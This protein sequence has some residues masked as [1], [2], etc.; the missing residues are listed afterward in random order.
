MRELALKALE[1]LH[2]DRAV[3][4]VLLARAWRLPA[5]VVTVILITR[6]LTA[7]LQGFY[8]TFS[9]VLAFGVFLELGFSLVIVN[10]AGHEWA[11]L[12]LDRE[13]R[14]V[15][16]PA[17]LSRLVSLGRLAFRWYAAGA[18]L[19]FVLIASAGLIFFSRQSHPGVSWAGPWT[20]LA[21]FSAM[22]FSM[23]SVNSL[24]EGCNQV[25]QVNRFRLYQ[26]VATNL[27]LWTGLNL[28]AELWVLPLS[29]ATGLLSNLY[30]CVAH[31]GKFFDAFRRV[32][33]GQGIS[34]REEVWPMQWRVAVGGVTSYFA[35]F[36][37]N[38]IM[39]HYHGPVVAG[40]MGMTREAITV[41]EQTAMAWVSTKV[42][43]YGMLI[44]RKQ[45]ADLDRLWQRCSLVSLGV[46]VV[47]SGGLLALVYAL[48]ALEISLAG[49]L[50]PLLPTGV[51]LAASF[52]T[53]ISQCLTGYL[54]AHKQEPIMALTVTTGLSIGLA[55]WVLG[56]HYGPIGAAVG[57]LG[58]W[59]IS[60]I[61]ERSIWTRCRAEWHADAVGKGG[62]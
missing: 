33:T 19:F 48:N 32:P 41:L 50:L 31:Y 37:F 56:S 14:V 16:D 29:A 57:S 62:R 47:G 35:F 40:R 55:V 46:I 21:L 20:L 22:S 7:E 39:F 43:T 1:F 38:P 17:A 3:V 23:V 6:Y 61:W 18:V 54:R 53:Q 60:V 11:H 30:F 34:W 8:Y 4:F 28:G 42:P 5:A 27:V 10:V 36:L 24:L 15:G 13:G 52:F 26:A 44:S 12:R 59:V 9:S 2:V 51:F 49:R 45:Y 25:A 58:I